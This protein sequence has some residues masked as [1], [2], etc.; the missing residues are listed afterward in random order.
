MNDW[1]RVTDK[2]P[3]LCNYSA[4]DECGL[5]WWTSEKYW[6]VRGGKV[7]IGFCVHEGR[8]MR[9]DDAGSDWVDAMT[10]DIVSDVTHYKSLVLPEPPTADDIAEVMAALEERW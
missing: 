10:S 8:S 9:I 2:L 5:Y 1:I 3:E 7:S 6:I 4:D